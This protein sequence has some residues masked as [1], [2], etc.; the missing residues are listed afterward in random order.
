[1][2]DKQLIKRH[3]VWFRGPHHEGEQARAAE[4]YVRWFPGVLSARKRGPRCL[5]VEYDLSVIC[6]QAIRLALGEAGFH[7]DAALM[8]KLKCALVDYMEQNQRE[9][10]GIE[11]CALPTQQYRAS[12]ETSVVRD[13]HHEQAPEQADDPWRHYL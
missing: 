4:R 5:E 9:A 8:E 1:M 10:L 12:G 6:H 11:G 2:D 7:L 3:E 13:R